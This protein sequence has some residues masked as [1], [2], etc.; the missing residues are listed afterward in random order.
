M[1]GDSVVELLTH[2]LLGGEEL[3]EAKSKQKIILLKKW[4]LDL[5]DFFKNGTVVVNI[6]THYRLSI[7]HYEKFWK[8]QDA[9]FYWFYTL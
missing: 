8:K 9:W 6:G 5:N 1:M 4:F 3:I 7:N 2:S